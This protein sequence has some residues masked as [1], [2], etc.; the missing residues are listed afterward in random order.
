MESRLA[1]GESLRSPRQTADRDTPESFDSPDAHLWPDEALF[2][3]TLPIFPADYG[4]FPDDISNCD[5]G[6]SGL[7]TSYP[8]IL[9]SD[10]GGNETWDYLFDESSWMSYLVDHPSPVN[11]DAKH[12]EDKVGQIPQGYPLP[13]SNEDEHIVNDYTIEPDKDTSFDAMLMAD[14]LDDPMAWIPNLERHLGFV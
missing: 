5:D 11:V 8:P 2:A 12:S 7:G 4:D 10:S 9:D 14:E 3:Q 13:E 1:T 6:D